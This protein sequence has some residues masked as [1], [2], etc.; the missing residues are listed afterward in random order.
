MML[1]AVIS[2]PVLLVLS[3]VFSIFMTVGIIC[4]AFTDSYERLMAKNGTDSF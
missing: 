3:A 1:L 4:L 2:F